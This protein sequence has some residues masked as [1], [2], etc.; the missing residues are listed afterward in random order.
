MTGLA[1]S[2]IVEHE[3][4][5]KET[6]NSTL[7]SAGN[8]PE[9]PHPS[10]ELGRG[11]AHSKLLLFGEHAAVHGYPALG[12]SLPR[13]ATIIFA[14]P[15]QPLIPVSTF[16]PSRCSF[17]FSHHQDQAH[18]LWQALVKRLDGLVPGLRF[19]D[20]E[21]HVHLE[22]PEAGGYGSSAALCSALATIAYD[23]SRVQGFSWEHFYPTH[24][25]YSMWSP[26][27]K[28]DYGIWSLANELEREFHGTPSGIDTGLALYGCTAAF[29]PRPRRL[30]LVERLPKLPIPLIYGAVPRVSNT[31]ALVAE[32]IE[33]VR[34]EKKA[35]VNAM[36]RLGALADGAIQEIRGPGAADNRI[37]HG[38][39]AQSL[40]H[41][42]GE[43]QEQL[44]SL[45]LGH[46]EQSKI[47]KKACKLGALGGKLSGA[48]GGGA[49]YLIPDPSQDLDQLILELEDYVQRKSYSMA[50]K[51]EILLPPPITSK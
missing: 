17:Y 46:K 39:L 38:Y 41:L 34:N 4:K 27:E 6:A 51:L 26:Q 23:F 30:P 24:E 22:A 20:S 31:K 48:G 5:T 16:E 44:E 19:P 21:V 11:S 28:R 9:E 50:M 32:V 37:D 33:Q 8:D 14:Q 43:A 49:F 47:I 13:G 29:Y 35:A 40:A 15:S 2:G 18:L 1:A 12:L 36:E 45:G 42:A 10:T 3:M 25:D 7:P